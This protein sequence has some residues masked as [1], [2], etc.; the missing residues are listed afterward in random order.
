MISYWNGAYNS[1]NASNLTYCKDGEI[2]AKPITGTSGM[3]YYRK[4]PDGYAELWGTTNTITTNINV[5]WGSL[6]ESPDLASNISAFPF[7]FLE[8]PVVMISA[9]DTNF[10]YLSIERGSASTTG[11]NQVLF[12]RATSRNGFTCKIK[13]YV[14]GKWK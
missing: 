11:I 7:T 6:Y 13:L 12:T 8:P 10:N 9:S 3:W 14:T 1:S 5:A 2:Q 4:W